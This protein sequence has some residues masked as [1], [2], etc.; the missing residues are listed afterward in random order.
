MNYSFKNI[1][2]IIIASF[3]FFA[4]NNSNNESFVGTWT[5]ECEEEVSG[6][7]LIFQKEILTLNE[8]DKFN[9]SFIYLSDNEIDTLAIIDVSGEW[10]INKQCLEMEYNTNDINITC[11]DEDAKGFFLAD[12]V[13]KITFANEELKNAHDNGSQYGIRNVAIKEDK[14]ISKINPEDEDGIIIYIKK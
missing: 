3:I 7:N 12:I 1:A 2:T 8:G 11:D 13:G 6:Y 4:C 5:V 10:D 9:K 14:M